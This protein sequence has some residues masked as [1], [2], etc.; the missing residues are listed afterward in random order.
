MSPLKNYCENCAAPDIS[1]QIKVAKA[2]QGA[3]ELN[4]DSANNAFWEREIRVLHLKLE[5][6]TNGCTFCFHQVSLS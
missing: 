1:A 6:A 5:L 4:Q 3:A 2:Y